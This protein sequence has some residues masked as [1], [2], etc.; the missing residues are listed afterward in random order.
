[1]SHNLTYNSPE[2]KRLIVD[3]T[4]KSQFSQNWLFLFPSINQCLLLI[5]T[6]IEGKLTLILSEIG[7]QAKRRFTPKFELFFAIAD[8]C[9]IASR[10]ALTQSWRIEGHF[11]RYS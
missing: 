5:L 8:A 7:R 4:K 6:L 9:G 2:S 3:I 10:T 11:D 1:M